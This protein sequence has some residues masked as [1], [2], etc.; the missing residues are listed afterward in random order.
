VPDTGK[1]TYGME[2]PRSFLTSSRR[3][4]SPETGKKEHLMYIGFGTIV[5]II[6][7]I[8][9]IMVLRRR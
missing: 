8:A 9:V 7:I 2:L 5:V 1:P 6:I 3:R 4:I